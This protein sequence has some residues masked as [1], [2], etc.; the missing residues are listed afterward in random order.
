[1]KPRA[2]VSDPAL[3]FAI[4]RLRQ[5]I[6]ARWRRSIEGKR[7]PYAD[8]EDSPDDENNPSRT[9]AGDQVDARHGQ[10]HDARNL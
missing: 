4:E 3:E 1:M 6:H 9:P 2:A 7:L 10:D 8:N 5:A